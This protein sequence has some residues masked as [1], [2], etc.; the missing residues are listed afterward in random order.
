MSNSWK[1]FGGIN[2]LDKMN[3]LNVNSIV[4]DTLTLREAY[5]GAFDICGNVTVSE[6]LNVTGKSSFYNSIHVKDNIDISKNINVDGD[7]IIKGNALFNTTQSVF[8]NK[9]YLGLDNTQ[10]FYGSIQ[11]IGVNVEN[12]NATLDICGN[13]VEVLNIFSDLSTNRNIIASN[14]HHNGIAVCVDNSNASI[15][16]FVDISNDKV[17][18]YDGRIRYT[19]GG[20]MMIDVSNNTEI[21][22]K[23]TVSNRIDVS[24]VLMET[25]VIYDICNNTYAYDVYDISGAYTGNALSLIASDNSSNTFLNIITPDQNGLSIGGGSYPFDRKLAMGTI[26]LY[27]AS[28]VYFPTQNIVR[29]NNLIKYKT[30]LG[31]N[32]HAP[33]INNY[34]VDVN[35]PMHLSNG[36]ITN[37]SSKLV[38]SSTNYFE[39]KNV[40]FS[41][42]NNNYGLA[43]GSPYTKTNNDFRQKILYT[44][45]G[46]KSWFGTRIT[47]NFITGPHTTDLEIQPIVFSS[48]YMYDENYA[49]IAG[50]NNYIFYSN[51]GGKKWNNI[52]ITEPPS[53]AIGFSNLSING[54]Y[55]T[56]S[57]NVNT[58]YK[59]VV[60]VYSG[61]RFRVFD[62]QLTLLNS[63]MTNN[64]TYVINNNIVTND[65]VGIG[66]SFHYIHGFSN[67]VYMVGTKIMKY[68]ILTK[69]FVSTHN[70]PNPL[71]MEYNSVY[72]FD[73]NYVIA[74]G[75]HIISYSK[76]GG[77][78]WTHITTNTSGLNIESIILQNVFILNSN[79]AI[80][81]GDNGIIVYTT[82]G[83][84]TWNTV[85][86]DLINPS[87]NASRLI[88]SNYILN[89]VIMQDIN[90]FIISNVITPYSQNQEPGKTN[91][92]Y[93]FLPNLLNRTNNY[94]LDV[95]GNMSMDGDIRINT[96]KI[97]VNDVIESG[98]LVVTSNVPSTQ[99]GAA[100]YVP[101]GGATIAGNLSVLGNLNTF[102]NMNITGDVIYDSKLTFNNTSGLLTTIRNPSNPSEHPEQ[103]AIIIKNN[104]GLYVTGNTYIGG[105]WLDIAGELVMA[106]NII[107]NQNITVYGVFSPSS[108]VVNGVF[109]ATA[110]DTGAFI[111]QNGGASIKGNTYIGGNLLVSTNVG[112]TGTL[113]VTGVS[114][115][116]NAVNVSG[117]TTVTNPTESSSGNTGAFIVSGGVGVAKNIN[118]NGVIFAKNT[119]QSDNTTNG[120]LVVSGGVGIAKNINVG[121]ECS[122]TGNCSVTRNI[123][124][125]GNIN[126]GG[127]VNIN[128][129]TSITSGTASTNITTGAFVVTGGVGVGGDVNIG[130][131]TRLPTGFPTTS[132]ISGALV[133]SGNSGAGIAGNVF[134]G[135]A[136]NVAGS[137]TITGTCGI[138]GITSI[139]NGTP[140]IDT[141]NGAL[142]VTGSGGV[143]VGGNVNIGGRLNVTG[144]TTLPTGFPT[145]NTTSGALVISG[146]SGAGIGGSVFI[147][148]AINV[149]GTCSITQTCSIG[150]NTSIT[151]GTASG[152]TTSGALIVSG[153]VGIGGNINVGGVNSNIGGDVNIGGITKITNTAVS[154]GNTFGALVV[155]GG[156]GI[157]GNINVGGVNSNIGGAVNISGVTKITNTTGSDDNT[158]GA[159]VVSGG[160][161]IG[162]AVNIS[163]ITKI[164]NTT[165]SSGNTSGALQVSGGVGIIGNVN[166]GGNVNANSYNATSDYRIKDNVKILD[167]SFSI[168]KLKPVF[169]HNKLN[170]N[171]DI[172]FIAH[173]VQEIYPYLVNGEKDGEN[174]QTLN[175]IGLIGILVHEIQELKK[176]VAELS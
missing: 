73:A 133:I 77:T 110:I 159:L 78:S 156:V 66:V 71:T 89:S 162:G 11:G 126:I 94:I 8:Y 22:S 15:D 62:I 164:T 125:T 34:V 116:N 25:A 103:G 63:N 97:I 114:N 106:G 152:N 7:V 6:K 122:I 124:T 45:N 39:I 158:S 82:N 55:I 43:F 172:G 68:N 128:G 145:A 47:D 38:D 61:S 86:P 169:Y 108:V 93:C 70:L 170:N 81:V 46:G 100:L 174:Y 104:G 88:N 130:G 160:V 131:I 98:N 35:G 155:S 120:S 138:G 56:E 60:L 59:R 92:M 107:A 75:D 30:T 72:A 54:V 83:A 10:Y 58:D 50:D 1:K 151:S 119:I 53:P 2:K 101:N 74:V 18:P 140:S 167:E 166:I 67:F 40:I 20:I 5:T 87:G 16:F 19:K 49:I 24:H 91:I 118:A 143:G 136:I 153:G 32:T 141:G 57:D 105:S 139:T 33:R 44:R 147:G 121:G 23:L 146:N 134:I 154:N 64:T 127:T 173:E 144:V 95:S 102:Q 69:T 137:S 26:G 112:I 4:T 84:V 37:V 28:G 99:N 129:I 165:G 163:G 29:G 48:G 21:L 161:G 31:I 9:L 76:N 113:Q 142:V 79:Y 149:A 109:P 115:L 123:T 41:R 96:G 80:A 175:Y 90:S 111:V 132:T 3:Y 14:M 85:T 42:T 12:P 157:A 168:D 171:N 148:G 176:K 150:G 65:I 117:I 13:R 36:E 51:D 135:G 27:D 52:A 17:N